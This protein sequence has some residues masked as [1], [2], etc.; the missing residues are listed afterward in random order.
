MTSEAN[1]GGHVDVF[2]RLAADIREKSNGRQVVYIPNPGNYG[3]GLIRYAT[4]KFFQDFEIRHIEVNVGY[5]RGRL[6]LLPFLLSPKKYLFVYGGGGAWCVAYGFGRSIVKFI[7][8]FTRDYLVLPSTYELAPAGKGGTYYRRDQT[9]SKA[10]VPEAKFCHDMAIYLADKTP[11]F[12]C[13]PNG[14]TGNLF[15]TDRESAKDV[16]RLPADNIDISHKGNHM[17]NGDGFLEMVSR[18]S[19]VNTDRLHVAIASAV[20]GCTVNLEGGNYF[21]IRAIYEASLA[22]IFG[23]RIRMKTSA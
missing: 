10:L 7:S 22:D 8:L 14:P 11:L 12:R 4:K 6:A 17:S 5:A 9:N 20:A 18:Y 1:G 15:R 23:D 16:G 21:K 19:E 13:D 3:D 2:K